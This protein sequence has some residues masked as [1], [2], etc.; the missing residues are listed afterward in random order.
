VPPS[1]ALSALVLLVMLVF[2][3]FGKLVAPHNP[4]TLD[5]LAISR[6]PSMQHWLGTDDLG[7]DVF[8]R[9]IVGTRRALGGAFLVAT[10]AMA[11]GIVFGLMAGYWGGRA[12]AA[13]M[14]A[15]DF[16]YS[17]PGLLIVL[18]VV[19]VAGG[20]FGLT[21]GLLALLT[22]PYDIRLVRGAALEQ[23]PR[24][25][26]EAAQVTGAGNWR[27]MLRHI[28]PNITPLIVANTLL[29]FGFAIVGLTGLA[30]LGVGAPAGAADWGRMLSD[31]RTLIFTNPAAPLGPAVTIA[32]VACAAN[33]VGDWIA[34]RARA[35]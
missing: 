11:C 24:P 5:I 21:V 25:Y 31:T 10:G 30:F 20:G 17:L 4:H 9:L 29:N 23:R 12:D 14:R 8:S 35:T 33:I 27:I 7:R 19:G 32:L 34:D 13:I 22:A 16:L 6:P 3:V 2:A 28:W 1:V 26:I 15:V 18:V